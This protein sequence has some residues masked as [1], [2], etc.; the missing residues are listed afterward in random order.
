MNKYSTQPA[1][2]N[3][4]L[5]KL[6]TTIKGRF[7][8][9]PVS[10]SI[11]LFAA[12]GLTISIIGTSIAWQKMV[13]QERAM[14]MQTFAEHNSRIAASNVANYIHSIH[15]RLAFFTQS[16]SLK[17]ALLRNDS[18]A[19]LENNKALKTSFPKANAIRVFKLDE[20][21]VDL[22]A[23]PPLHFSEFDIIQKAQRRETVAPEAF[24]LGEGW[25]INV[26]APVPDNPQKKVVG[27]I[28]ISLPIEA[29]YKSLTTDIGNVGRISLYQ[30]FGGK[31]RLM[32]S[33]GEG[34]AYKAQFIDVP[35]SPWRVEFT[36]SER[37]YLETE[38]DF[39][40][41]IM[42]A[43]IG[44]FVT[45]ASSIFIGLIL[46]RTI[47]KKQ[48]AIL[49]TQEIMGRTSYSPEQMTSDDILNVT[50]AEEDEDLLGEEEAADGEGHPLDEADSA[51]NSETALDNNQ[52]S[53][54]VFRSYDIRG[55]ADSEITKDL[56]LW[57]GK[58]LGSEALDS[59]ESALIVARD[60]RIHSPLLVENLI[61]GIMDTGC[62]VINIGTV[63]TPLMYFATEVFSESSS[64]VMVTA[65]HN[66]AEHNGFKVV[67]NGKA[68]TQKQ[69]MAMYTKITQQD[70]RHGMGHESKKNVIEQYIETIFSDVALASDIRI[71][72]DAGNAVPGKVAPALFEELGCEVIPLYCDLDGS[73]PH[74]NPDPSI[75]ENLQDLIAKVKSENAHLG[76]AFDGDG[77]RL[78]VVTNSGK[79]IWPDRL[80]MLFAKDIL[81][82]NPG[83][84]VV[85]DVKS[86]RQLN[87][88]INGH[89]GRPI[90]WKTGHAPMRAKMVDSG[91]LLGGEHSG[92]IFIKDRWYGFDDGMYA[93]ARLIEIMSLRDETLD[94]IFDEFPSQCITPEIRI[95]VPEEDKFSIVQKLIAKGNFDDA[96]IISIDGLRA[97]YA[98][99]WGLVRASNTAAELTLRFEADTEEQIHKLKSMFTQEIRKIDSTIEFNW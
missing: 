32:G 28:L 18:I 96:K 78:A 10:C 29:L 94:E 1:Q 4:K 53:K 42:F 83:A 37:L 58:A 93:A 19:I 44:I 22:D 21:K 82:R 88:I 98:Y 90:M 66:P 33:F 16:N 13:V 51:P 26:V 92:H 62:H 76:V 79:I 45:M 89:G 56:A 8:Q 57:V 46:G 15:E 69:I 14:Q 95:A 2:P 41:L 70:F 27:T 67:M 5:H 25:Q 81:A 3:S 86:S 12:I 85:F 61:R 38:I 68:R 47:L 55:L 59:G 6:A 71:V 40:L 84:D 23:T 74:H 72:I 24:N 17:Q 7:R 99:G 49:Q 97:E 91:A 50:I 39:I 73:F 36:A 31:P 9:S 87:A 75:A 34:E 63:P 80:L 35:N 54:H 30:T 77:D 43:V 20:A 65:S 11:S 48:L 60:A 52:V 64:G